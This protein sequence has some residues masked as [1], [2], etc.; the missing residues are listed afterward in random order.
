MVKK[1]YLEEIYNRA[2]EDELYNLAES[3]M[4][5]MVPDCKCPECGGS[6]NK[7]DDVRT[8][9]NHKPESK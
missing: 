8:K 7:C 6:K 4:K 1:S 9:Y 3:D 5:Q 2:F